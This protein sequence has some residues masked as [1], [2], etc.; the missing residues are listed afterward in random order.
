MTAKA[1]ARVA[2]NFML[3]ERLHWAEPVVPQGS[4]PFEEDGDALILMNDWPYGIDPRIVHL[5]VWTKFD[6]PDDP[7]TEAE[8]DKFVDRT[9]SPGISKDQVSDAASWR[10]FMKTDMKGSTS[11][12]KIHPASSLCMPLSTSM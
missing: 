12:S 1:A 5:V 4:R 7:E 2:M 3:K 8:V 11:G 9:F 10:S 6:L